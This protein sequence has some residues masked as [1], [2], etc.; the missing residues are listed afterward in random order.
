V[1]FYVSDETAQEVENQGACNN[2]ALFP[3]QTQTGQNDGGRSLP[4]NA[5]QQTAINN[6]I[7]PFI[8]K[9]QANEGI[10]FGQ[11]T[12]LQAPFCAGNNESGTGYT[13]VITALGGTFYNVC[14]ADPGATLQ[15][16]IDIVTGAASEFV[17]QDGPISATIKVGLQ[18]Q[19]STNITIVPRSLLDGFDFSSQANTI[20]FRGQ[21]FQPDIGDR[22]FVSYRL[23]EA[24]VPIP[25]CNAPLVLNPVTNQCECPADC[26]LGANLP[27]GFVCD[28][29]PAV[30]AASCA[31]DCNAICDGN[32]VCDTFSCG[33]ICPDT[34]P[35][36]GV[37]DCAGTVTPG[38]G[39]V[40]DVATCEPVCAD[41]ILGDNV[42][43][44]GG[45]CAGNPNTEC[46]GEACGCVC[47]DGNDDG[48]VD[49]NNQCAGGTFC[50]V[51]T[52]L[53]DSID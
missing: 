13:D 39:F 37:N 12:P 9:I 53:C 45:T 46:D 5:A 51:N 42:L 49:C 28:T 44:C 7:A 10:A 26:G 33:C 19:G 8:S 32:T 38:S 50:N 34:T 15:N 20:F 1:T 3:Q 47:G 36:D 22:V 17:L 48:V 52:C 21:T 4:P 23:W 27:P 31:P 40:C 2:A 14:D 11:I 29:D 41:I 24:P 35:G 16:I 43:D 30:C 25:V 18:R 6:I